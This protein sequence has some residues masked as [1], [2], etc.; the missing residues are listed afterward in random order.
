MS[1]RLTER[2]KLRVNVIKLHE[3]GFSNSAITRKLNTTLGLVKRT[4]DK[5][6][7]MGS[8]KDEPR[9]GRPRQ[10]EGAAAKRLVNQV[11]G[12]ERASTRKTAA[13]FKVRKNEKVS[14]ETVRRTVKHEGLIPHRRKRRPLLTVAE[15]AKRV[16]FAKK[17]LHR[18]WED[19]AF[20]DEKRFEL[21]HSPNPKN[22]IIWDER[23]AEYFKEEVKYPIAFSLGLAVT[24][25]G[26]TRVVPYKG[27]IDSKKFINM[28]DGPVED[29]DELFGGDRY[30]WLMDNASCHR[31]K[32][33]QEKMKEKVPKLFPKGDW[34]ANSPDISA[35]ENIFGD[36]Q[37]IVD[38]KHPKDL[39]SLK[40][41]VISEF[42][43]LTP[44]KCQKFIS[45]LPG[46]LKQ[47]IKTGGE[48]CY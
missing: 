21:T 45:A 27:T 15:K 19:T 39:A 42:K 34:P 26:A 35:I 44:E 41:I 48:Y 24:A 4:L 46:R 6:L 13:V 8:V 33:T 22:D 28:I 17:Y 31:S 25:L 29:L 38:Q 47:I 2:E 10:V 11:K 16:A 12:R 9:S 37:D 7:T 32:Y 23:G 40:R 14:R 20:W 18:D 3:K 1:A 30:E 36:V 5:V 43:K